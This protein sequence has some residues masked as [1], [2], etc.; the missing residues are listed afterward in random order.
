LQAS[1]QGHEKQ[2]ESAFVADEDQTDLSKWLDNS[3]LEKQGDLGYWVGY[4]IVKSYY[5]HAPDKR[6]ALRET[7]EMT[8]PKAFLAKSGWYPGISL[9]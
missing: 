4:R 8:D 2:I 1:T 9:H 3:T 5:Q 7:I 6:R